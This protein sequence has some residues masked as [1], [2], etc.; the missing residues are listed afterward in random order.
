MHTFRA[1]TLNIWSSFGPWEQRLLGIRAGLR[2]L[3]PDVIGLQ[4]VLRFPEF[5]QAAL[6]SAGLG[7]DRQR[8]P[9]E[10]ADRTLRGDPA[11]E[12]RDR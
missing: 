12:R 2:M 1:G 10:V 8:D 9:L 3:A 6:T 5:D 4:E 7:Y 11:P